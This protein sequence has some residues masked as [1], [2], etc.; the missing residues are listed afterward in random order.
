MQF[1]E[2]NYEID[3]KVSDFLLHVFNSVDDFHFSLIDEV[4][5]IVSGRTKLMLIEK[6][7]VLI[8]L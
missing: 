2:G 5:Q 6:K 4:L 8:Y 3:P 7:K 1:E